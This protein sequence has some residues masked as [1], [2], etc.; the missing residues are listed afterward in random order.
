[1]HISDHRLSKAL[2]DIR[3]EQGASIGRNQERKIRSSDARHR[4]GLLLIA[5]GEKLARR[6]ARAA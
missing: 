6:E 5:Q 4:L 1:M 3:L 2:S